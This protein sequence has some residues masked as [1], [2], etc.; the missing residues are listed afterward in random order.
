MQLTAQMTAEIATMVKRLKHMRQKVY[1]FF[2]SGISFEHKEVIDASIQELTTCKIRLEN[3]L[4]ETD[5]KVQDWR[6]K[7][8]KS[9]SFHN[10]IQRCRLSG[11]RCLVG[12]F[13]LEMWGFSEIEI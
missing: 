5:M 10:L 6:L 7:K 13:V 8:I 12:R 9:V 4:C 11:K 2:D 1:P 3:L